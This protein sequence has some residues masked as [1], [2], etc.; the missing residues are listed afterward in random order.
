MYESFYYNKL[1]IPLGSNK[2]IGSS[3][4]YWIFSSRDSCGICTSLS[5][6]SLGDSFTK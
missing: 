2:M 4:S 3:T 5:G 6:S 1:I